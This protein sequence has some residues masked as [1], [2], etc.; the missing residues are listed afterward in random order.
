MA[1]LLALETLVSALF[2]YAWTSIKTV[3]VG[4]V[5]GASF[6]AVARAVSLLLA[7]S[8]LAPGFIFISV[9]SPEGRLPLGEWSDVRW[10][11]SNCRELLR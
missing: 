4:Y 9:L 10:L 7:F 2:K 8:A 3:T 5:R 1:V 11:A 6:S